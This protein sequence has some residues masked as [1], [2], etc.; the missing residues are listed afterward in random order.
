MYDASLISYLLDAI[1]VFFTLVISF[2]SL[3][4]ALIVPFLFT[5]LVDFLFPS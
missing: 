2:F 1:C 4:T 5:I 3:V